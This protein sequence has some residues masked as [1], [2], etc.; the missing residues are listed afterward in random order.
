MR[1]AACHCHVAAC[2]RHIAACHR[3]IAGRVSKVGSALFP[4][5]VADAAY[6]ASFKQEVLH[7]SGRFPAIVDYLM[8]DEDYVAYAHP[9]LN[10]DNAYWW[11]DEAGTLDAGLIDWSGFRATEVTVAPR[12]VDAT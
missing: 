12:R 10:V 5:D 4:P 1:V 8:S 9:N 11:R 3:H 6:M 2:H 7:L